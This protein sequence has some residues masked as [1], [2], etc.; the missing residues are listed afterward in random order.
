MIQGTASVSS[1]VIKLRPIRPAV[2]IRLVYA[3]PRSASPR[4]ARTICGT[5]TVFSTPPASRMYMLFGTVVA[6]VNIS[7][8]RVPLPNRYTNSMSRKNPMTRENAVPAAIRTLAEISRLVC[9]RS[10]V[11]GPGSLLRPGELI[12]GVDVSDNKS[13]YWRRRQRSELI[14]RPLTPCRRPGPRFT[15][16]RLGPFPSH[17]ANSQEA[18]GDENDAGS[19]RDHP[20]R[21]AVLS[22]LHFDVEWAS[23][24]PPGLGH[25]LRGNRHDAVGLG[26]YLSIGRRGVLGSDL[27][28]LGRF[29]SKPL[30]VLGV[31]HKFDLDRSGI[32]FRADAF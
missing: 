9:L 32:G 19:N 2:M 11:D 10:S 18:A 17:L 4:M 25:Q 31:E 22:N 6:I 14:L 21:G 3:S 23:H 1:S 12:L 15:A 20:T 7:A 27:G 26:S 5:R 24:G 13:L 8:C 29:D 30:G 16:C 28:G